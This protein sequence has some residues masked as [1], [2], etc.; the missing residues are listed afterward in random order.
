MD[1]ADHYL[2]DLERNRDYPISVKIGYSVIYE[3]QEIADWACEQKIAYICEGPI[4]AKRPYA[5]LYFKTTDAA[6]LFKLR[7]C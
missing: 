3:Y 2:T 4:S 6:L 7:F 5:I 1:N